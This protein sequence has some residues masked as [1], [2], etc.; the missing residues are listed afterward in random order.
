MNDRRSRTSVIKDG[1]VDASPVN[2]RKID[3]DTHLTIKL[4]QLIRL[5]TLTAIGVSAYFTFMG[6][7]DSLEETDLSHSKALTILDSLMRKDFNLKLL[8]ME[9][10]FDNG[11]LELRTAQETGSRELATALENLSSSLIIGIGSNT[12][13]L[14]LEVENLKTIIES[15]SMS[16]YSELSLLINNVQNSLNIKADAL[17]ARIELMEGQLQ[18]QTKRSWFGKKK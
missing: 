1:I 7:I 15:S 11:L 6:R 8:T 18:T 3:G 12:E 14:N 5:L 16:N 17:S 2:A 9:T 13:T 10:Q 4:S